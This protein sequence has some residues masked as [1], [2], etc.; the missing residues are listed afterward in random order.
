MKREIRELT[1]HTISTEPFPEALDPVA[2]LREQAE[3][4]EQGTLLLAHADDGVIW[5]KIVNGALLTMPSNTPL[6]AETLQQAR[7]F[8]SAGEYYV[9]RDGDGKF[10]ARVIMDS[11]GEPI[12]CF[13]EPQ[14]LWGDRAEPAEHG[15]TEMSDGAQGLVHYVPIEVTK[16]R[17]G[18]RPLRLVVRHYLKT[19]EH[20]FVR[21]AYS[22]LVA[23]KEN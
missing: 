17:S 8:N 18:K 15:F 23:L 11:E 20:G 14:I 22:R 7:L 10:H 19:D 1:T 21:V 3:Q 6:R 5:G 9:W 13:D 2:W 16:A 4:A 12:E